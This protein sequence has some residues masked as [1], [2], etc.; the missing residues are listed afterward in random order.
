M[1][2]PMLCKLEEKPWNRQGWIWEPKLDGFRAIAVVNGGTRL[3]GRTGSEKTDSFPDL[4]I[5]TTKPAVLDG[6][7]ISGSFNDIQ[8]RVNREFQIKQAVKDYPVKFSAFDILEVDGQSVRN[9]PLYLRKELLK[10]VLIQ[11]ARVAMTEYETDGIT[12]FARMKENELE[13]VVGKAT[14]SL[15]LQ[16]KREWVKVKTWQNAVFAVVGYTLGTGW[17]ESTFGALVLAD[18]DGKYV[19]SVGTGFDTSDIR[20]LYARL[21]TTHTLCPWKREPE[22]ATWVKPFAVK[23]QFLEYTNDGALRFPSFKGVA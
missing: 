12:L 10:A 2:K 4:K 15:Y 11:T 3:F 17:R 13:G 1:Y 9:Q 6:E 23:I 21:K 7:V 18:A 5:Q 14:N 19:G 16:G 8:H 20:G 22:K